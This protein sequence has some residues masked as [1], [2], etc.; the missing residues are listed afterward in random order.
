MDGDVSL[1]AKLFRGL[2]DPSR[3]AILEVLR[4]GEKAVSE[5]VAATGLSQPN[6]SSHLSCLRSCGLVAGRQAGRYVFYG[7]SDA[8]METLIDAAEGILSGAS[9][10]ISCCSNY[11]CRVAREC[12][13]NRKCASTGWSVPASRGRAVP[14]ASVSRAS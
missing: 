13:S 10:R 14:M 2:S 9:D 4:G 5:I 1:K 3:L 11:E 6:V 7:L 12:V 8:R